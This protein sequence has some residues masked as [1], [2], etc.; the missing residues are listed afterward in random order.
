MTKI[1]VTNN[2]VLTEAQ[3][4][5]ANSLGGNFTSGSIFELRDGEARE[6]YHA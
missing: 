1:V 2:Q 3:K 4:Q 5:R 6:G